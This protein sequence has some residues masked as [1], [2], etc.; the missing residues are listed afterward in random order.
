MDGRDLDG[1]SD[2][3]R[4]AVATAEEEAVELDHDLLGT[5]HLLL[6]LLVSDEGIATLLGRNGAPLAA[7]RRKVQE[8]RPPAAARRR[9]GAILDTTPRAARA[10]VRAVRFA[11]HARSH[12]VH[13]DHLLL[14]VIDVEGTASLV[15]RGLGVDLDGLRAALE[16]GETAAGAASSATRP[17]RGSAAAATTTPPRCPSCKAAL[18]DG[19]HAHATHATDDTGNHRHVT[20]Y[21]CGACGHVLGVSD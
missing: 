4:R 18:L 14:A 16:Q 6:G 1:F 17:A 5:E 9:R 10:L 7:A 13:C 20:L 19:V 21:A 8:A 2:A 11:H 3:A 12:E 15:L